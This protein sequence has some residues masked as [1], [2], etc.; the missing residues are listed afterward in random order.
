MMMMMMM[1]MIMM[2][3]VNQSDRSFEAQPSAVAGSEHRRFSS[4]QA[5]LGWNIQAVQNGCHGFLKDLKLG[6]ID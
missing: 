2:M 1:M 4:T 5:S 6:Q 3:M